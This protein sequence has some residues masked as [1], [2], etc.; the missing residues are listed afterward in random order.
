[1]LGGLA[2]LGPDG[3]RL[4]GLQE[5][6]QWDGACTAFELAECADAVVKEL[7]YLLVLVRG[8]LTQ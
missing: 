6:A 5:W 1:M 3:L 8:N 2:M 4:I 7:E